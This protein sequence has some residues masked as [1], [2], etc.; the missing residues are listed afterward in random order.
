MKLLIAALVVAVTALTLVG[1]TAGAKETCYATGE[2]RDGQNKI[3]SY[4]CPS[5]EAAI[6]IS[7]SKFCPVNITR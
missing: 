4:K 6:T 2:K 5:G 3:C 7:A 1:L